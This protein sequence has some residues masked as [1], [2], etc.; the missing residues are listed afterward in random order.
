MLA[1][2]LPI[3]LPTIHVA[4]TV[5][6]LLTDQEAASGGNPF[7]CVDF[8]VSL[9]LVAR[10]DNLTVAVVA[11]L[12]TAWWYFVGQIA[13]SSRQCKISRVSSMLGAVLVLLICALDFAL[14]AD[15]FQR[16]SREPKFS[17][18]DAVIYL[19]AVSLLAGGVF[20]GGVAAT[21]VLRSR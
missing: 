5:L 6:T 2:R 18:L 1:R 14:M 19:L 7:F 9:P 11:L 17:I 4:L 3:A 12:A 13:W 16:I 20:S 15:E 21:S 8:P 10:G